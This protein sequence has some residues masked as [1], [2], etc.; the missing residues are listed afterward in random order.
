MHCVPNCDL[1]FDTKIKNECWYTLQ[2]LQEETFLRP[3]H[4]WLQ[5]EENAQR[6][7]MNLRQKRGARND[8]RVYPDKH[9]AK[10]SLAVSDY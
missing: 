5:D 8:D 7:A 2:S 10:E 1:H 9:H 3:K 4:L 6:Q